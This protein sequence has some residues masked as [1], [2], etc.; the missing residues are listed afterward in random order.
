MPPG[1]N[2]NGLSVIEDNMSTQSSTHSGSSK[3]SHTSGK[4][5]SVE[6]SS[7]NTSDSPSS[8]T[9]KFGG[10]GGKELS[11]KETRYVNRLRYIVL[12]ILVLV[13]AGVSCL[14]YFLLENVNE[15]EMTQDYETAAVRILGAF[16]AIR[17]DRVATLASLAI[18]A[19]AHGVD[20]SRDWPFVSLSFYQQRSFVTKKESGAIQVSIAPLVTSADRLL[21]EE[22]ICSDEPETDWIFRSVVYQEEIGDGVYVRDYG[23]SFRA[24]ESHSIKMWASNET[25]SGTIPIPHEAQSS[26]IANEQ[27]YLPL[28][29][30]SPFLSYNEVNIDLLRDGRG[31]DGMAS[32]EEGAVV[33]SDMLY[34]PPGGIDSSHRATSQYAELLSMEKG[35]EME[36]QGDAMS[37][38]YTPI[39]D[40]F[41]ENRKGKAVLVGL[42]NWGNLFRGVLPDRKAGIDLVLHNNCSEPFTY[43]FLAEGEVVPRGKGVSPSAGLECLFCCATSPLTCLYAAYLLF[44][45]FL[46]ISDHHQDLHDPRFDESEVP[47]GLLQ[48]GNNTADG[49]RRGLPFSSQGCHYSISIYPTQVFVENYNTPL[50]AIVLSVIVFVFVF[51]ILLFIFYDRLVE[52]RQSLVLK[53]AVQSTAIVSSLFPKNV[54]DRLMQSA[55]KDGNENGGAVTSFTEKMR[56]D[57][58]DPKGS[59]GGTN[60]Y[61]GND[62][63]ADLFPNCT[64]LFADI[65]GFTAWSSSRS[66]E[67]VFTLLQTIYQAFDKIAARRRVFKVETIGDSYV[68]VTGLPEP[69]ADHALIMSK[70]AKD[71]LQ[72]MHDVTH[73]LEVHLGPDTTELSMRFGLNS[74][75]VTGGVL[76]GDRARFQLFGDTVN[77]AARMEST[78]TRG[79]IQLSQSTADLLV[80]AGKSGWITPR[81]EAVTAKGKGTL[82]T[83]WL[84]ASSSNRA[85]TSQLVD[86][87]QSR[88]SRNGSVDPTSVRASDKHARL[89]GWMS[90]V[91]IDYVKQIVARNKVTGVRLAREAGTPYLPRAG[92]I[93]MDELVESF[94]L[95]RVTKEEKQLMRDEYHKVELGADVVT[96]VRQYVKEVSLRY[97]PNNPFHNFDHA[98][99][100]TM[101]VHK[102]MKRVISDGTHNE[103]EQTFSLEKERQDTY[104][105]LTSDPVTLF[106]IIFSALIHDV[107]HKGISNVQ[108]AKEA[109]ELAEHYKNKSIAEQ[110]SFDISWD[111]LMEDNFKALR[112]V[113]FPQESDML[114]FRQVAINTVLATDIFDKEMSGMRKERW[115]KVFGKDAASNDDILMNTR[116]TIVLEHIIQASDVSHTMQHWHVYVKWN[117]RLFQ[118]MTLAYHQGRMGADPATFWYAGELSFFDNYVIPLAKKIGECGVF[119]VSSDEYLNYALSNRAEWEVKGQSV[120]ADL[121]KS[122]GTTDKKADA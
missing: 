25:G 118:E 12:I 65:A 27:N 6:S 55:V 78:G 19:I 101:S 36:Y 109:P 30:V 86:V 70:F 3:S 39:F 94:D 73:A 2:N 111:L 52:Y 34:A 7:F 82:H 63:I 35:E 18:A 90:E 8:S 47:S 15:S 9:S 114:R 62:T 80:V 93:C 69:Q 105:I 96:Q 49:T 58:N 106:A 42:F 16:D 57:K 91:L 107:D 116:A 87:N 122:V 67:Q 23:R 76:K 31:P 22:Y 97:D 48:T 77:T 117:K 11:A 37:Y 26:L 121:I 56:K 89:I 45:S 74:G 108:L 119:G 112:Q 95:V 115:E 68:A 88:I 46:P 60:S 32:I 66:P 100:V 24:D 120:V 99:H 53:R 64:V 83:Y 85:S 13:A 72:A 54:R 33:V 84:E 10:P 51:T 40:S 28:W 92:K 21:Y 43:H 17:T 81:D 20:H 71:C 102:L 38:I 61:E 59:M 41:E 113:I 110:N 50:P 5:S 75:Q 103:G 14:V 29:E 44:L 79:M 4:N 104:G 98:C 1:T